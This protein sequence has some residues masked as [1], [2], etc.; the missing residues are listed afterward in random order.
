MPVV[1][2]VHNQRIV[3]K[4]QKVQI[5]QFKFLLTFYEH[6]VL[7]R[8]P[9]QISNLRG[10]AEASVALMSALRSVCAIRLPNASLVIR[11]RFLVIAEGICR[12]S[13]NLAYV[14][15]IL[16]AGFLRNP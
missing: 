6:C 4:V 5:V 8:G 10:E 13:R 16:Y 12:R 11:Y 7:L 9:R 2:F 14:V 15:H 1:S 3:F